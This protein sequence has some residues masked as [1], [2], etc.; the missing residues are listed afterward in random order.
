VSFGIAQPFLPV[1]HPSKWLL[2]SHPSVETISDEASVNIRWINLRARFISQI[3]IR[4]LLKDIT[5]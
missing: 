5:F 1:Y 3:L 2:D 4:V